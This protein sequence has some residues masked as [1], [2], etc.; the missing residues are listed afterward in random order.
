MSNSHKDVEKKKL[1]LQNK[2]A[3]IQQGLDH[4]LDDVKGDV[5]NSL[6]PKEVVKK[7]PLT[8]VGISIALGFI[9]GSPKSSKKSVSVPAK[10]ENDVVSSISRSLKKRLVQKAVDTALDFFEN[11][12]SERSSGADNQ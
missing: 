3:Q 9:L 1:E 7:Y 12:M 10:N 5:A 8:S 11:K 4:S 6:S 2:I